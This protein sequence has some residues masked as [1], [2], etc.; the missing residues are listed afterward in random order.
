MVLESGDTSQSAK[1]VL[2]QIYHLYLADAVKREMGWF[3]ANEIL[4]PKHGIEVW[5]FVGLVVTAAEPWKIFDYSRYCVVRRIAVY[6]V[7]ST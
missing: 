7:G 2:Q 4:P 1:V 5:T 3:I 6:V